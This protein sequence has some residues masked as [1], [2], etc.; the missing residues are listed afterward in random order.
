MKPDATSLEIGGTLIALRRRGCGWD[1]LAAA[2]DMTEREAE[3]MAARFL[4]AT[5]DGA[6]RD[7]QQPP[8]TGYRRPRRGF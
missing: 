2:F 6:G 3:V 4:Q 7:R 5:Q 8:A 1:Q